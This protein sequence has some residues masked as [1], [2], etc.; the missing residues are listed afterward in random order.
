MIADYLTED[1]AR[2]RTKFASLDDLLKAIRERPLGELDA[3]IA[4]NSEFPSIEALVN[5]ARR[6]SMGAT[7]S[8][9]YGS[10]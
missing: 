4:A 1:F 2:R 8:E 5:E 3:F 10:P 7:R 9:W 6:E